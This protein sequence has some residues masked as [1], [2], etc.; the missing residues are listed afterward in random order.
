MHSYSINRLHSREKEYN[1]DSEYN[2]N[3]TLI[4]VNTENAVYKNCKHMEMS[5][6]VIKYT[7]LNCLSK[8][9][10]FRKWQFHG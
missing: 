6:H 1:A 5:T 8:V 9:L 7:L 2:D 10:L 4:M 3:C